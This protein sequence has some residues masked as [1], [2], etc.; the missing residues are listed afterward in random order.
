M[1]KILVLTAIIALAATTS[2]ASGGSGATG[3]LD[4][5]TS[6]YELHADIDGGTASADTTLIGK[7]STGVDVGWNTDTLGY[8]LMTQHKQGTK[9]YGSSYDSTAIYQTTANDTEPGTAAYNGGDLN[10]ID[11]TDFVSDWKAL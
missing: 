11:T 2:F 6:G 1:K 9:A 10:D 5:A 8:A 3:T 7:C 4:F